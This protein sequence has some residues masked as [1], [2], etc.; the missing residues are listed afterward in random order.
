MKLYMSLHSYTQVVLLP[1]GYTTEL[2]HDFDHMV[3]ATFLIGQLEDLICLAL[4][5][6]SVISITTL[7][8]ATMWPLNI[9]VPLQWFPRRPANLLG[10]SLQLN[11]A[12]SPESIE[13]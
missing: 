3:S 2:P 8:T 11:S 4:Q 9:L 7:Y 6:A 12:L 5:T 10:R 13:V 1:W